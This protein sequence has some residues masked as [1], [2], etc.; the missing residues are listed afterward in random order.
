MLRFIEFRGTDIRVE[1][2][3]VGDSVFHIL[4]NGVDAVA[5]FVQRRGRRRYLIRLISGWRRPPVS[6]DIQNGRTTPAGSVRGSVT[7]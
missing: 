1:A 6:I 5:T 3:G 7:R 2:D 4:F